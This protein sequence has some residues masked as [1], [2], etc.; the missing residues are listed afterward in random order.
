M[1]TFITSAYQTATSFSVIPFS[2]IRN[3]VVKLP[4]PYV[5]IWVAALPSAASTRVLREKNMR[6]VA[7]KLD[8][9]GR[10]FT[11]NLLSAMG[12]VAGAAAMILASRAVPQM[13]PYVLAFAA[14]NF[15]YV[16]MADLIPGLH[17]DNGTSAIRQVL[18]IG[19]G[20]G[21]IAM[22]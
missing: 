2:R 20:I 4:M 11:L 1:N 22:L 16:A 7:V 17:R 5:I 6:R 3:S 10:A 21:T 8:S 18:L 13:L 9:R 14:G 19:A 12:G 15:L